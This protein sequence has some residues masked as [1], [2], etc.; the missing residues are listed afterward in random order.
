MTAI[1][2]SFFALS[3]NIRSDAVPAFHVAPHIP[4]VGD[5]RGRGGRSVSALSWLAVLRSIDRT[6]S[7]AEVKHLCEY[8]VLYFV[9]SLD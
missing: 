5:I 9:S 7:A 1:S 3:G 6:F 8:H 4:L 2:P